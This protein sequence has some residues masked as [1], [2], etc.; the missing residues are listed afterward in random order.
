[1]S[2][3]EGELRLAKQLQAIPDPQL[4]LWFGLNMIP[5]VNDVDILLW[6]Q[7]AGIFLIVTNFS[8][9]SRGKVLT[10]AAGEAILGP[11]L[12]SVCHGP[13]TLGSGSMAACCASSVCPARLTS[14]FVPCTSTFMGTMSSLAA[15]WSW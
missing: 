3:H 11:W 6:H 8:G 14:S 9:R 1:M 2:A 4:H 13:F 10:A 5:R 15:G 7:A 12:G